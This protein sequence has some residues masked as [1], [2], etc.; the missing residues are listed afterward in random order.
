[1]SDWY[2]NSATLEK[3]A[4]TRKDSY[5]KDPPDVIQL[6]VADPDFRVAPEIKKAIIQ[7]VE[8]EDFSY[9]FAET[10]MEEKCAQK[11]AE[12]NKIP[13]LKEDIHITNGT[14]PGI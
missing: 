4:K 1:M 11:L 14:I 9:K 6:T 5:L 10:S 2:F 12:A 8:N 13:A 3:M 7:A